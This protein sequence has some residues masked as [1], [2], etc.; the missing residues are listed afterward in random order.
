MEDKPRYF[1]V[2]FTTLRVA[3]F[4]MFFGED[5]GN[6]KNLN[7]P[8][9]KYIIPMRG[10]FENPV[11][12]KELNK[13]TYI[14]YWIEKDESLTQDDYVIIDGVGYDRQKC[15]ASILI[16]T[17]GKEAET[18]IKAFRHLTK[19]NGMGEIWSGMCNA[20]KLEYTSPIR[21]T[22]LYFSGMNSEIAFDVR[23][24]LYYD[25]LICTNWERLEGIN[26][27]VEGHIYTEDDKEVGA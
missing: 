16:R 26:F 22:K 21:P 27:K 2:N 20:E 25:E 9:Y 5:D 23:F 15:V 7:S 4:L 14:Q 1:G 24:K 3:L 12:D 6:W 19:R 13:D 17:V 10:N 8:K 11:E 18:W